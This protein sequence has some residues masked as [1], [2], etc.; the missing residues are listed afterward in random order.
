MRFFFFLLKVV[1]YYFL[2][3]GVTQKAPTYFPNIN[4]VCACNPGNDPKMIMVNGTNSHWKVMVNQRNFRR[5]NSFGIGGK[6]DAE[7]IAAKITPAI[8]IIKS[9]LVTI[10]KLYE[11]IVVRNSLPPR[12]IGNQPSTKIIIGFVARDQNPR[13]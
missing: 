13:I 9:V 8:A 6:S 11:S 4:R 3:L 5:F 10:G 2:C 12:K 7:T 1:S